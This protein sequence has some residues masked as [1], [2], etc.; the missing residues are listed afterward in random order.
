MTTV[1]LDRLAR[2][3]AVVDTASFSAAARRLGL[4]KS[5]VSRGVLGLEQAMGVQLLHRTTRRVAVTTAGAALYERTAPLIAALQRSLAELP[6]R[7]EQPSGRLRITATVDFGAAVLADIVTR[8]VAR[9]PNVEVDMRLANNLV[10]MVAEG[11][12]VAFRIARRPLGDASFTARKL[13]TIAVQLHASPAYLARRGTPRSPRELA[14][15]TWVAYRG[16]PR[17]RLDG[18][19]D[20][21][22]LKP[23]GRIVCDDMS[24][25]RQALRAGAG[26]GIL[27]DFYAEPD[28]AAGLLVRVL[29]RWAIHSGGLWLVCAGGKHLPRKVTAFRE[30]VIEAFRAAPLATA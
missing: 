2:F 23:V 7:E 14:G 13:G 30:F 4:P 21:A 16:G 29:P 19:G 12:D 27:P 3:V 26:L 9:Y 18:P 5:S 11:I 22:V 28:V 24:F 10:D 8:F 6:E 25:A 15:H 1:D 17:L 20:P